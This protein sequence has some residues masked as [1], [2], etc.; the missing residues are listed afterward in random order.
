V[1]GIDENADVYVALA[2]SVS[3]CDRIS[4]NQHLSNSGITNHL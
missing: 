3:R 2:T 1:G 4:A